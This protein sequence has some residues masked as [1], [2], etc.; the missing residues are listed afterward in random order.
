MGREVLTQVDPVTGCLTT[1]NHKMNCQGYFRKDLGNKTWVMYHRHIWELKHGPIPDKHEIDHMCKN[2]GCFNLEHLQMLSSNAHR[3]KDN[4]ERYASIRAAAKL[5]WLKRPD[6]TGVELGAMF[7][8][9]PEAANRWKVR[10]KGE[11][12]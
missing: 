1:F 6:I 10:W 8:R 2:R 4:V 5:I 11:V 3:I 12:A 9:S 7:N